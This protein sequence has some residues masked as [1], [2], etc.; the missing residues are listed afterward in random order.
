MWSVS[1]FYIIHLIIWNADVSYIIFKLVLNRLN[2]NPVFGNTVKNG[3]FVHASVS[4]LKD[5][6]MI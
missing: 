5:N 6:Q 3:V 4:N 1:S 2:T